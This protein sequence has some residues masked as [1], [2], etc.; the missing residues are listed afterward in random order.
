M[1]LDSDK[2]CPKELGPQI[3]AW[4][5]SESQPIPCAVVLAHKEFEAWFLAAMESLRGVRGIR[6]DAESHP[7]PETP[8]GAKAQVEARM[9]PGYSYSETADQ[10][11][12]TAKMDLSQVYHRSR[13]FRKFVSAFGKV[14]A[15]MGF[16]AT[17]WPPPVW[18][19]G[20]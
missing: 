1:L 18:F 11:A 6:N 3:Q 12:M 13:S 5:E 4:A 2:D 16:D 7:E 20:G 17:S 8:R 9:H 15:A 10:A 19:S 14:V